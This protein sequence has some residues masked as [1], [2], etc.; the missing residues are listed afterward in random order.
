LIP[1]FERRWN[2][3]NPS[4]LIDRLWPNQRV[5]YLRVCCKGFVFVSRQ[6]GCAALVSLD[7]TLAV[8]LFASYE[9]FPGDYH[10]A[11]DL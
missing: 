2:L 5:A 4:H 8:G 9:A 3:E 10:H 11:G 7:S 6:L 1:H